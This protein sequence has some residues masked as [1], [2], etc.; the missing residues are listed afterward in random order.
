MASEC[1]A[2]EIDDRI[3]ESCAEICR[4]I[5]ESGEGLALGLQGSLREF[6]GLVMQKAYAVEMGETGAIGE[7]KEHARQRAHL[8][9]L[10]KF[11]ESVTNE[12]L[13]MAIEPDEAEGLTL[14]CHEFMVRAK[15]YL[16]SKFGMDVFGN[17]D[18]LYEEDDS[19]V[20][21]YY[22]RIAMKLE[23]RNHDLDMSQALSERYYIHKVKPFFARHMACY[24][25]T[26]SPATGRAS[27]FDRTIAFTT[28]DISKCYTSRLWTVSERVEILGYDMP[29]FVI[30]D[31]EVAI[32]PVEI[33]KFASV[34]G[35]PLKAYANSTEARGLF[36]YM[37]RSGFNLVELVTCKEAMYKKIKKTVMQ[38][39]NARS[40]HLFDLFDKCR[41]I[42]EGKKPGTN[43]LLYLLY[44]MNNTVLAAQIGAVNEKLS[45][46]C[47]S[48][49]CLPFEKMPFSSSLVG[50]N[51][52]LSDLLDCLDTTGRKHEL[53][54]RFLIS[55][56]ARNGSMYASKEELKSF[57]NPSDLAEVFNNN[58]YY[59]PKHQARRIEERRDCFY[60][61]GYEEDTVEIIKK[62]VKRTSRG[63]DDYAERF[64]NW[65]GHANPPVDCEEKREALLHM[66]EN[67]LTVLIYGSAGTGKT[68]LVNHIADLFRSKDKLYLANTN[69]AVDNL[70][71]KVTVQEG[72]ETFMTI[73]KFVKSQNN[74]CEYDIVVIDECSAVSNRDMRAVLEK[75][76]F[77]LLVLAGDTYQIE[78]IE[79]G[80]W[81]SAARGFL[82]E[83]SII[84][85]GTPYRSHNDELKQLWNMV[86]AMDPRTED[87]VLSKYSTALDETLFVPSEADEIILCLNY[88]GFYGINSI[89]R[90]LQ[91]ANPNPAYAWGL[92]NYKVGDPILFND[93]ERFK[94]AIHNNLKGWIRGIELVSGKV[95][96]DVEVDKLIE[97]SPNQSFEII[98]RWNSRT[99]V[100]FLVD[101]L[102]KVD[103]NF[104]VP[105][106]AVIPFQVAYA[107]SIHKAQG[108]EFNSVKIVITDEIEDRITHSIFY[109]AITRARE[110]L[111]IY[112]SQ[113]ASAK[114]LKKIRPK[115]CSKD[116]ELLRNALVA[117]KMNPLYQSN[118]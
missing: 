21:E 86:R 49:S 84:E 94:P 8:K 48:Y 41:E 23:N 68:T 116:I 93:T 53:L 9:F 34:F 50:H 74:R 70:R 69:P 51:P 100:R 83:S 37:T 31:W 14:K 44:H 72:N 92:Q 46:L 28:L 107:V 19:K 65:I 6:A 36:D 104:E 7:A 106:T 105:I 62:L 111:K 52:T 13:Q 15:G 22:Q 17:L 55:C 91:E 73:T 16:I 101:D 25:V 2:C 54:S 89:N 118:F 45:N 99:T 57:K 103:D 58:L 82:P 61:R 33:E 30:V 76:R 88:D 102:R 11:H 81:F 63:I 47:L 110:K 95:Q 38:T 97:G 5:D 29:I 67:S 113:E 78:A 79:F 75:A 114:I 4:A 96:F 60:I 117:P 43:V 39:Y 80:N 109:T 18:K 56:T 40:S 66:F 35:V 26:F 27:K 87:L 77:V 10:W 42:I 71:R 115:S 108:L 98:E 59:S 85:L 20:Q 64:G 112:W 3:K 12:R 32:R 90:F 1:T 24:E